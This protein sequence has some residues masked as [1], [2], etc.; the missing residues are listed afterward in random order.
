MCFNFEVSI[1]TFIT[2]WGISLYLLNKKELNSEQIYDIY[3]LMIF[4][5]QNRINAIFLYLFSKFE[6][7]ILLLS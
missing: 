4:R 6:C 3:F 2:T 1:S 7:K 5:M